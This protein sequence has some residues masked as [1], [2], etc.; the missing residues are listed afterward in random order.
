MI[1]QINVVDLQEAIEKNS[2]DEYVASH[3]SGDVDKGLAE[4]EMT[5][6]GVIETGAQEHLY[7]EPISALVVPKREDKEMEVFVN[8]QESAN[9]QV[10]YSAEIKL[11]INIHA[12][13]IVGY[14]KSHNVLKYILVFMYICKHNLKVCE[15]I[16]WYFRKTL[17]TFWGYPS[18]GS[19]FE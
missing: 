16:Y 3:V 6:E 15:N 2:L 13:N 17:V 10:N 19:V 18:T 1:I 7:M 14:F 5:L 4:A 8:T 11:F 12:C 9:C